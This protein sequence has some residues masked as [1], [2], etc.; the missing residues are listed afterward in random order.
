MNLGA[1]YIICKF[2]IVLNC[3]GAVRAIMVIEQNDPI[4]LLQRFADVDVVENR[5]LLADPRLTCCM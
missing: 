2:L 3:P 5:Q 1:N 4:A